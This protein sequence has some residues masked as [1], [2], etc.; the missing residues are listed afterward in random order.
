[1][2]QFVSELATSKSLYIRL[3]SMTAER[4][5]AEFN[6][7]GAPAAIESALAGCPVTAPGETPRQAPAAARRS[8]NVSPPR[9]RV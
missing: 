4:N 9:I 1:M 3:R 6:V 2:A 8:A 7:E 5:S